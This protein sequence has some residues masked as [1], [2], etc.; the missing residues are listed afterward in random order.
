MSH[1]AR[2]DSTCC[3]NQLSGRRLCVHSSNSYLSEF[4]FFFFKAVIWFECLYSLQ[5]HTLKHSSPTERYQEV[6]PLGGDQRWRVESSQKGM[7]LLYKRDPKELSDF[8]PLCKGHNPPPH[9][10]LI[11]EPESGFS[12]D[13]ASIND[14]ILNF[15]V[16]RTVRNKFSF[17]NH[18][19]YGILL[20][21]FRLR[22][23]V[24]VPS[25]LSK[26]PKCLEKWL[27]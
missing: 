15:S 2:F 6:R 13:T 22:Q 4:C 20:Q 7:V 11:Y 9:K 25:I 14:L 1:L 5:I 10:G 23:A 12:P 26:T 24:W 3:F 27:K 21:Q 18:P 16:S 19:V 17:I 8:L